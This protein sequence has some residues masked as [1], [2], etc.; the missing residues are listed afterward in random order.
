[1]TGKDLV[2]DAH[3]SE[4]KFFVRLPHPEVGVQTHG[5]KALAAHQLTEWCA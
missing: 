2:E 4:R 3:L 1:M 5:G